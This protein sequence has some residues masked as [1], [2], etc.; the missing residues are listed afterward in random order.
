MKNKLQNFVLLTFVNNS[1]LSLNCGAFFK[2]VGVA[3]ISEEIVIL[4]PL[5]IPQNALFIKHTCTCTIVMNIVI[6]PKSFSW[7]G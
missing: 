3:L 4:C 7:K 6:D 2:L 5:E 1:A